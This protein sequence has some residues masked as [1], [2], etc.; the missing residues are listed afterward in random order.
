MDPV[1]A[2]LFRAFL[3]ALIVAI[4]IRALLSWFPVDPRAPY[5][6]FVVRITEPLLGPV[7]QVVP[8]LGAIDLSPMIVL[9]L[10]YL[11]V[12]VIDRLAAG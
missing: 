11:M 4:F 7:R 2:N 5:Y 3:Y 1:I 12:N 8:R 9:V 6:Q 10:L